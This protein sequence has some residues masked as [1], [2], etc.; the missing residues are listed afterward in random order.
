ML[1]LPLHKGMGSFCFVWVELQYLNTSR[2]RAAGTHVLVDIGVWSTWI[3]F[4][5]PSAGLYV[6]YSKYRFCRSLIEYCHAN[7]NSSQPGGFSMQ[8]AIRKDW[9]FFLCFDFGNLDKGHPDFWK[10]ILLRLDCWSRILLADG[11][12]FL[13][14]LVNLKSI[15]FLLLPFCALLLN[16]WLLG[17]S[18]VSHLSFNSF[19]FVHSECCYFI[20][21]DRMFC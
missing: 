3:C 16:W 18:T 17:E 2:S 19:L 13:T 4:W 9:L 14:R 6:V 12:L 10:E 21:L 1:L 15:S 11:G 20:K 5:C 8:Y 7:L